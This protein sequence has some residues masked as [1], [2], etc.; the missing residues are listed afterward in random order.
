MNENFLSTSS[1]AQFNN[2]QRV[3]IPSRQTA[4]PLRYSRPPSK[5]LSH[6]DEMKRHLVTLRKRSVTFGFTRGM[7]L[8][9]LGESV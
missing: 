5:S 4:T 8:S 2:A 6:M 3:L 7:N 9:L 1:A